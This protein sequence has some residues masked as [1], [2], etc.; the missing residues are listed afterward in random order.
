MYFYVNQ[1][2]LDPGPLKKKNLYLDFFMLIKVHPSIQ[3]V[4]TKLIQLSLEVNSPVNQAMEL[5][6]KL[7][8][9]QLEIF[10]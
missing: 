3:A 10:V 5:S 1:Y 7:P 9:A 6:V 4:F 2:L 8:I